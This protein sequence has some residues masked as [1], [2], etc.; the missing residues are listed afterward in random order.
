MQFNFIPLIR[1]IESLAGIGP[2][3]CM[4]STN[5]C[6]SLVGS[7]KTTLILSSSSRHTCSSSFGVDSFQ[8]EPRVDSFQIRLEPRNPWSAVQHAHY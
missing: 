5:T 4:P 8:I 1:G 3:Y 6:A 2:V 7:V